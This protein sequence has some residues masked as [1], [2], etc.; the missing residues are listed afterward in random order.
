[1]ENY[2]Y[3]HFDSTMRIRVVAVLAW[4]NI[5]IVTMMMMMCLADKFI[6]FSSLVFISLYREHVQFV[7][8]GASASVCPCDNSHNALMA[9]AH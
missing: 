8:T 5:V 3:F 1:M 9:L 2:K 4:N 6:N 7:H